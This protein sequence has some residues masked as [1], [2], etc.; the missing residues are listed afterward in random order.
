[1]FGDGLEQGGGMVEARKGFVLRMRVADVVVPR[2][3]VLSKRQKKYLRKM[4]PDDVQTFESRIITLVNKSGTRSWT[5][6]LSVEEQQWHQPA[7]R[8]RGANS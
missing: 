5:W 4:Q 1:M 6:A 8:P 2:R 7:D 3:K